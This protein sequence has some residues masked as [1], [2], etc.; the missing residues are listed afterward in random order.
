MSFALVWAYVYAMPM[1]FMDAEFA[2]WSAKRSLLDACHVGE[3]LVLGDSRTAVDVVPAE[4]SVD[5]VNLALA[6]S[7]T[8]EAYAE[9]KRALRCPRP[10]S[11]IVLSLAPSHLIKPDTFW[12]KSTRYRF[13]YRSD[14]EDLYR[15][16]AETGDWSIFA[17]EPDGLPPRARIWLY[18]LNF[19]TVYFSSLV[20][21]GV[22]QTYQQN[23]RI[24]DEVVAARGQYVFANLGAPK[25]AGPD[26]DI[27]SFDPRPVLAAFLER[28]A[29]LTEAR[30]VP[31]DL[32][33][34]PIDDRTF[35]ALHPAFL[36]GYEDFIQ[37]FMRRHPL[38]RQIGEIAPHWPP[39]AFDGPLDHF[40]RESA[41]KYSRLFAECFDR[42]VRS[43]DA[44]NTPAC[45]TLGRPP[46]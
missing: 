33:T 43:A 38:V 11:R 26:A 41:P 22:F 13:L 34:M 3:L 7:S 17:D 15:V 44:A 27:P 25:F 29:A 32:V 31:L 23:R 24:F 39:S 5:T 4:L 9:L 18:A 46:G 20:Q 45:E 14:L 40:T 30:G 1:A 10:P 8:V 19:P 12:G 36:N 37:A 6:G 16:S 28:I 42:L 35:A 21:Q 2:R